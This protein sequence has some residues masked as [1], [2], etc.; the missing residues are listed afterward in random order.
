MSSHFRTPTKQK[1]YLAGSDTTAKKAAWR[2][3]SSTRRAKARQP[4]HLTLT[5]ADAPN[6]ENTARMPPRQNFPASHV[7][8]QA[9]TY[10]GPNSGTGR[11][12]PRFG[13]CTCAIV[14]GANRSSELICRKISVDVNEHLSVGRGSADVNVNGTAG[15]VHEARRELELRSS[16]IREVPELALAAARIVVEV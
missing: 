9:W 12:N 16:Y 14:I 6:R 10:P 1:V 15:W 4:Y 8:A 13:S 2:A 3:R 7:P 5:G 11:R